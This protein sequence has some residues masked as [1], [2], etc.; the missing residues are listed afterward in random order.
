M[1]N[2]IVTFII[3]LIIFL[4]FLELQEPLEPKEIV[5]E[6]TILNYSS[7]FFNYKIIR[8]PTRVE[9]IK[10]EENINVGVVTDP[11]NLNFGYIPGNG[12]SVK[13]YI[14]ILNEDKK[15][16]TVK[17]KAYGN[18]SS[19]INFSKNDFVLNESAAV[20]V[21]LNTTFAEIGNYTGEIDIIIKVPKY[22][23]LVVK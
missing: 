17:L 8:Y 23:F 3:V 4:Y 21:I 20:E 11:W 9:V 12:S 16:S 6:K 2:E 22:D 14:G 18:I 13:R 5:N 19:L 15:Y 10:P 7:L 1:K